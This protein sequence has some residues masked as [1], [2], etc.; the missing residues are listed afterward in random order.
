MTRLLP[1]IIAL[2]VAAVPAA[3]QTTLVPTSR[4]LIHLSFAPVVKK[5]APAVVN[6]FSRRVVRTTAG[7]AA[8]FNDPF[9]RRFFGGQLP[10][11][12]PR[13]RVENSLG[14]GVILDPAGYIVTNRHV[15][16][17]ADE[18]V[19]ELADRREFEAKIVL[20]DEHADLAVLKIDAHG[21]GLPV[22]QMGDSDSL[23]VGDL[24]LAI[25]NPFGV[26]QTVT[27]GIVSALARSIGAHDF[28]SFI[29][30]DAAINPGNSGGALVD[31]D[32]R[33]VGINTAIFS[34][35]G[36]SVGIGFAIPT[37]LVRGV[38]Q[39][40]IHGGKVT[41]PWLGASGQSVTPELAQGFG[42]PRP[43]GVLIKDVASESPA[44]QSG[45]HIGDIILAVNGHEV[46]DPDGLRFRIA[47]LM[48][49]A[50]AQL[51]V[52]RGGQRAEIAATVVAPPEEPAR[53][54]TR[55][56][57]RTPLSGAAV[58]N[59]NPAFAEELGLDSTAR[60]VIVAALAEGGIA[61]QLGIET[62][63]IIVGLNDQ[64]VESVAALRQLLATMRPP[65]VVTVK[66]GDKLLTTPPL[67]G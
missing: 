50:K 38:L 52:W 9:F 40:A 43:E 29:Q 45:I 15:I 49:G 30:T 54:L 63:D 57:G 23:E 66:R 13:E 37:S 53:D 34:Q 28:R 3:A 14:S 1:A 59:L 55:L 16:D 35:S 11:G 24:V 39:A 10:F 58:A 65:W 60:G 12:M 36:G 62:G 6:V 20:T 31:L 46:D 41:R 32:G 33:L 25:G 19:V 4:E 47:T 8:L 42:L 2:F 7:P 48:P 18:V 5:A 61:E 17:N 26:G 44:A 67:R 64:S 27:S 21:Q 56:G 22:L 51:T